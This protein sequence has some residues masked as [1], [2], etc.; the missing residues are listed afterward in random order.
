LV[1]LVGLILV[2]G[3]T[4]W[5]L[6]LAE[7]VKEI[8]A[9]VDRCRLEDKIDAIFWATCMHYIKDHCDATK[10]LSIY[11]PLD[12]GIDT[13]LKPKEEHAAKQSDSFA[14]VAN[15]AFIIGSA[16]VIVP[17]LLAIIYGG[18]SGTEP[19]NPFELVP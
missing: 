5:R 1:E 6:F 9:G 8:A 14:T 17:K 18:P 7:R 13:F 2:L 12:N 11:S 15:W 3:S 4:F 19:I 16:L 10:R